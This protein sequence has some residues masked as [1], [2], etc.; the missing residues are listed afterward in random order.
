MTLGISLARGKRNGLSVDPIA[1]AWKLGSVFSA[2]AALSEF[3]L[4]VLWLEKDGI[5]L[6]GNGRASSGNQ[7]LVFLAAII[8]SYAG[9]AG[10]LL[11]YCAGHVWA[12]ST[13]IAATLSFG[14]LGSAVLLEVN[15]LQLGQSLRMLCATAAT[16]SMA[17]SIVALGCR[18]GEMAEATRRKAWRVGQRLIP[19]AWATVAVAFMSDLTGGLETSDVIVPL[20][21]GVGLAMAVLGKATDN[22]RMVGL[23]LIHVLASVTILWTGSDSF[24]S[25]LG[26]FQGR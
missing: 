20:L 10:S 26:I 17:L 18:Q 7:F 21:A 14:C 2:L 11:G 4:L 13:A 5:L 9:V 15:S 19:V 1:R 6:D 16:T 12:C 25:V 3:P 22:S 23:G 8:A 24:R